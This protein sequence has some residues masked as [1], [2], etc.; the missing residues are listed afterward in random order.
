MVSD[1]HP[2]DGRE[3]LPASVSKSLGKT[4][5]FPAARG[6]KQANLVTDIVV[7]SSRLV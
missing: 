6:I 5:F 3:G 7:A 2:L 4:S 1:G